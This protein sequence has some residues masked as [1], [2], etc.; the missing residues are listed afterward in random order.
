EVESIEGL[1]DI[2]GYKSGAQI[3]QSENRQF[4]NMGILAEGNIKVK[5]Q[6]GVGESTIQILKPG[7]LV[8][9][10]TMSNSTV[11]QS[12]AK[13]YAFGEAK[14]LSMD[15]NKFESLFECQGEMMRQVI[16][17]TKRGGREILQGIHYQF[18]ELRNYI[19]GVNG[20]Y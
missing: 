12:P 3:K 17:G 16:L 2:R 7:D 9:A 14:V 8:D 20:L 19:Y 13:L 15:R 11:S 18:T 1:F 5:V 6:S 4:E 10:S